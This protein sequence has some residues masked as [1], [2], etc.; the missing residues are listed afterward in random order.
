MQRDVL[1]GEV[2]RGLIHGVAEAQQL[3]D[4]RDDEVGILPQPL[5]LIRVLEPTTDAA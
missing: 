5:E 1:V 3:L 2:H 4:A